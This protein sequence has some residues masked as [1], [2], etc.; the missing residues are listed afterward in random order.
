MKLKEGFSVSKIIYALFF[1]FITQTLFAISLTMPT[2]SDFRH[3]AKLG[4]DFGVDYE[5]YDDLNNTGETIHESPMDD[6][7]NG[8]FLQYSLVFDFDESSRW[9][10]KSLFSMGILTDF[11]GVYSRDSSLFSAGVAGE[12]KLFWI[13]SGYYGL[14]YSAFSKD[15]DYEDSTCTVQSRSFNGPSQFMGFGLELPLSSRYDLFINYTIYGNNFI[16]SDDEYWERE[17]LRVGLVLKL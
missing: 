3:E 5:V 7:G 17:S 2:Q 8:I 1:I 4:A 13:L 16:D 9:K 15:L 10:N 14:A 6:R 11:S 12:V